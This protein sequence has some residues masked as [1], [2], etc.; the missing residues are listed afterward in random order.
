MCLTDNG[1]VTELSPKYLELESVGPVLK[2]N[3]ISPS[4]WSNLRYGEQKRGNASAVS[5]REIKKIKSV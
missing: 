1:R 4:K 5:N 2:S 3:G